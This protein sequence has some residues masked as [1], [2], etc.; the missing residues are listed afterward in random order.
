MKGLYC[1]LRS[2]ALAMPPRHIKSA[3]I[4]VHLLFSIPFIIF[5]L[6]LRK[7]CFMKTQNYAFY[8]I[9]PLRSG[10]KSFDKVP[11]LSISKS[12]KVGFVKI[13]RIFRGHKSLKSHHVVSW[14]KIRDSQRVKNHRFCIENEKSQGFFV[15]FIK[16]SE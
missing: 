2:C 5:M 8:C 16:K 7:R 1:T 10:R 12:T 4:K 13:F 6:L 15:F 14:S 3:S 11:T 9:L